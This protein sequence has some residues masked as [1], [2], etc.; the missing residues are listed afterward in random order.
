MIILIKSSIFFEEIFVIFK[1]CFNLSLILYNKSLQCQ[2]K[3]AVYK[4]LNLWQIFKVLFYM[5]KTNV[6]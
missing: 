2:S 3:S 1:V 6:F 4:K 5:L